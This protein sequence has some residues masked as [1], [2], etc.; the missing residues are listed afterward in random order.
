MSI[1]EIFRG[2]K[3]PIILPKQTNQVKETQKEDADKAILTGETQPEEK[4]ELTR[5]LTQN[6]P[7]WGAF[8]NTLAVGVADSPKGAEYLEQVKANM[9]EMID[10][11]ADCHNV[12]QK[13]EKRAC[14]RDK[15][16]KIANAI[17]VLPLPLTGIPAAMGTLPAAI[18]FSFGK[19][20]PDT[21]TAALVCMTP[22]AVTAAVSGALKGI[23]KL[24]K[25]K[26]MPELK[27]DDPRFMALN[28]DNFITI[29]PD[30]KKF[31][32]CKIAKD[33]N[34]ENY[35][36]VIKSLDLLDHQ[37][38]KPLEFSEVKKEVSSPV[39]TVYQA[40]IK[41]DDPKVSSK[42]KIA[43]NTE[44][45]KCSFDMYLDFLK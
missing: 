7:A 25:P 24:I 5:N 43:V 18:A 38:A 42:F 1:R 28:K 45:Q 37:P 16:N 44:Q 40:K 20:D 10:H 35:P 21:A 27:I 29:P 2:H 41:Y 14:L 19:L 17:F 12:E 34:G 11:E 39:T 32:W 23:S 31:V 36:K 30:S 22:L 3:Q 26:D 9:Q 8:A 6:N 13:N 4:A 15:L 33:S